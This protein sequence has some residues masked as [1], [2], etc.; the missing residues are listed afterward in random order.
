MTARKIFD[1]V[2]ELIAIANEIYPDPPVN[3]VSK[4]VLFPEVVQ[5]LSGN[6]TVP[7]VLEDLYGK[8]DFP[9]KLWRT[10]LFSTLENIPEEASAY[11]RMELDG[12]CP[13]FRSEAGVKSPVVLSSAL[14]PFAYHNDSFYCIDT[15]PD[16]VTGG[17]LNQIVNVSYRKGIAKVVFPDL[18]AFLAD[19]LKKAR[20][21]LKAERARLARPEPTRQEQVQLV[22]A[23]LAKALEVLQGI[24]ESPMFRGAGADAELP[25]DERLQLKV[26]TLLASNLQS[27]P[28]QQ[29]CAQL[30]R[31]FYQSRSSYLYAIEQSQGPMNPNQ[32][33][34]LEKKLGI[35]IPADLKE[36]LGLHEFLSFPSGNRGGIGLSDET[37]LKCKELNA[38]AKLIEE[39]TLWPGTAKP[40]FGKHLIPL[41]SDDPC[42]CYDLTPSAQGQVGQIVEVDFELS[43]CQVIASS[44]LELIRAE[45]AACAK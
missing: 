20:K 45:V 1:V 22:E 36:F 15:D 38:S 2:Q 23:Q 29:S 14:F 21:E 6:F 13:P 35:R 40:I 37:F 43:Q 44:L 11:N 33:A 24:S 16:V 39:W 7:S 10:I 19:G 4:K 17:V 12:H 8:Y 30:I 18:E 28:L 41:N 5:K 26:Q 3:M 31:T 25:T 32:I 27:T 9:T 34:A 42:I